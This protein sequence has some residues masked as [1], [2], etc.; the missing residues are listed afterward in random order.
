MN[1][2]KNKNLSPDLT[3]SQ[4]NSI[5]DLETRDEDVEAINL[6]GDYV[7]E[8]ESSE[9]N[10][11]RDYSLKELKLIRKIE[12]ERFRRRKA[13]AASD[14]FLTKFVISLV[15]LCFLAGVAIF[16]IVYLSRGS[17]GPATTYQISVLSTLESCQELVTYKYHYKQVDFIKHAGKDAKISKSSSYVLLEYSGI[18]RAGIGDLSLCVFE[19]SEDGKSLKVMTPEIK[20]LGNDIDKYEV[21]DEYQKTFNIL[22]VK[23]TMRELDKRKRK[24]ENEAIEDGLLQQAAEHAKLSL[25]NIFLAAGFES[26]EVNYPEIRTDDYIVDEAFEVSDAH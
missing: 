12:R 23:D 22:P 8:D 10:Y 2:E 15:S 9:F 6:E 11:E 17:S 19:V 5:S 16:A 3:G 18:I 4:D 7:S 24:L 26:V 14:S 25:E 20:I 13:K 1:D 21:L